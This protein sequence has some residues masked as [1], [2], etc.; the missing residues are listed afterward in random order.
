M[1]ST[2][3]AEVSDGLEAR[4]IGAIATHLD[5]QG[6]PDRAS[7]ASKE[8]VAWIAARKHSISWPEAFVESLGEASQ[9]RVGHQIGPRGRCRRRA[10]RR[11]RRPPAR[12]V[13]PW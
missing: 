11:P 3:E 8:E 7:E 13:A 9:A 4:D 10:R 2:S 12:L 1:K 6:Q 5:V